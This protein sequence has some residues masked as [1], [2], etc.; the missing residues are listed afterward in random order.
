MRA[1]K[2]ADL[3]YPKRVVNS[4]RLLGA[5]LLLSNRHAVECRGGPQA[6]GNQ[7]ETTPARLLLRWASC[8]PG[9]EGFSLL[10]H[11]PPWGP[12]SLGLRPF[13]GEAWPG[14]GPPPSDGNVLASLYPVAPRE[15][16]RCFQTE[17]GRTGREGRVS[18]L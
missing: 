15:T 17:S 6:A 16:G 18:A 1:P 3:L 14:S 7:L 5:S 10:S 13:R 4:G 8:V 11:S 12:D 2:I 9:S